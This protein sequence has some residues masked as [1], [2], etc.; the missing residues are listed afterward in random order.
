MGRPRGSRVLLDRNDI[1]SCW[2][3]LG[4]VDMELRS[5]QIPQDALSGW[6]I[7]T[8]YRPSGQEYKVFRRPDGKLLYS[9]RKAM[10]DGLPDPATALAPPG[11]GEN[12][13][14]PPLTLEA[15]APPGERPIW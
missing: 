7:G 1:M 10:S 13:E 9:L 15:V 3:D 6:A 14:Q 12:G 5:A 11:E 2:V 4:D 8:R